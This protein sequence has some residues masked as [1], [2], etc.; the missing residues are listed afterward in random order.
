MSNADLSAAVADAIALIRDFHGNPA[1]LA[2]TVGEDLHLG[3]TGLEKAQMFVP[4]ITAGALAINRPDDLTVAQ[5]S[6]RMIE[7][8]RASE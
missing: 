5:W 8:L 4:L 3:L 6:Q 7:H 1:A 2:G